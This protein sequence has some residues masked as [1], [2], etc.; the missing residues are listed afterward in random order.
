MNVNDIAYMYN[1]SLNN[2]GIGG[3]SSVSSSSSVSVE[4]AKEA[5]QKAGV[6]SFSSSLDDE[7]SKITSDALKTNSATADAQKNLS[8]SLTDVERLKA[9]EF[10]ELA[11]A[12]D[13]SVLGNMVEG[14]TDKDLALMSEEMLGSSKGK[15]VLSKLMEGHFN[16]IVLSGSDDDNESN[17]FDQATDAFSEIQKNIGE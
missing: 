14:A 3:V 16:N 12:L 4:A 2:S 1:S 5:L 13:H 6:S 17:A 10:K 7:I 11:G 9:A 8:E 15:E